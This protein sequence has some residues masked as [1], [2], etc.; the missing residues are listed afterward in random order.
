MAI[1]VQN[2]KK[3]KLA[4]TVTG[5]LLALGGLVLLGV[6]DMHALSAEQ[7]AINASP[8]D[9]GDTLG[10]EADAEANEDARQAREDADW[11]ETEKNLG[12]GGMVAG[13]LILGS[14]WLIQPAPK[15]SDDTD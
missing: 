5:P 10:Y 14:R 6:G 15:G 8:S 1:T 4:V 13:A 9:W 7:S 3:A 11:A 12:I 2:P